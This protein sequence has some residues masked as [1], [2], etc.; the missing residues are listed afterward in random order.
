MREYSNC[1]IDGNWVKPSTGKYYYSVNPANG[2]E[3]A[4]IPECGVED[5]RKAIEAAKTALPKWA[6]LTYVE[7]AKY[8]V[9]VAELIRNNLINL[10]E[11]ETSDHGAP[12]RHTLNLHIPA[13]AD[14]LEFF[15]SVARAT[16]GEVFPVG[17]Q[18]IAYTL[19]EPIG[20]V[21]VITPW[22]FPLLQ[23]IWKLGAA[24]AM[25]NTVIVKPAS[26]TP[27]TALELAKLV[28]EVGIP[29]GV[30]NIVTGPGE[31]VGHELATNPAVDKVGLTGETE[32]GRTVMRDASSTLKQL[33]LELGG[34]NPFI[35]MDDADIEAAVEG[36]IFAGFLNAGQICSCA[37]RV[38]VHEKVWDEFMDKFLQS[39]KEI[40]VGDPTSEATDMGPL[41]YK[42]HKEK[43][44]GYIESGLRDGARIITD[45]Y[46]PSDE[47]LKEGFY[48]MPTIFVDVKQDM[49]MMR[50]EIFGPVVGCMRFKAFDEAIELANDS[51]YGLAAS[52]WTQDVRKGF[53]AIQKINAGTVWINEHGIT[54]PEQPWG[55]FKQSGFGKDCSEYALK[56]YT[57]VKSCFVDLIGGVMKKKPWYNIV[58]PRQR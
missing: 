37:S 16:K 39:T 3:H 24:I 33:S 47:K 8:L 30:V 38:Y 26:V 34:K 22:N 41:V 57:R 11:I 25:G 43:V 7:R 5:T 13:A 51:D 2:K 44:V 32:T 54:A 29:N 40:V 56:E 52:I 12:I 45:D 19:R 15:A 53:Y 6:S 23:V 1:F 9:K 35:V 49:K 58:N 4:K 31:T 55:G 46:L 21:G 50:E 48:V 18:G 20:V 10:A 28:E 42:Q 17:A 36:A 27:C 14:F